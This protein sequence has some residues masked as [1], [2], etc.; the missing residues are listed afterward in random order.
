MTAV[1]SPMMVSRKRLTVVAMT[2]GTTRKR[3]G[4][5]AWASRASISS[6]TTIVPS[7]AAMA[8][9]AKPVSTIAAMSGPSSRSTA[10]PMMFAILSVCPSS[11]S[12]GSICR[13]RMKPMHAQTSMTMP[14]ER[15]PTRTICV[16]IAVRP[17]RKRRLNI[18]RRIH[19]PTSWMR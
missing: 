13:A 18:A 19:T 9:P 16:M 4:F 12:G 1:T 7:S 6:P 8:A 11:E 5:R 10:T 2:R 17:K 15:T 3:T 14:M